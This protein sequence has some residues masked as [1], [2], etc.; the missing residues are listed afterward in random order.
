MNRAE[1]RRLEKQGKLIP[2]EPV[3]NIKSSD[4]QAIKKNAASEAADTAFFLMLALPLMVLHDKYGFG[5][6]RGERF[7][8]QVLEL[9]D[10]FEKGY[11]S[12]DDLHNCLW[13]EG[14]IK[15]ERGDESGKR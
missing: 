9:Y 2:K 7:I 12:L 11:V 15:I 10:S 1:R 6:V 5:K 3:I 14:G 8:D 13:E 4:V